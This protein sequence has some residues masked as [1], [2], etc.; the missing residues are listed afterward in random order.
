MPDIVA[1][2]VLKARPERTAAEVTILEMLDDPGFRERISEKRANKYQAHDTEAA[3]K[4]LE[5]R[6]AA[7]EAIL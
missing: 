3:D 2:A 4:E 7:L 5:A 1:D 6:I